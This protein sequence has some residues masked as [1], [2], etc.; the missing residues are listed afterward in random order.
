MLA[1]MSALNLAAVA[2]HP[3]LAEVTTTGPEHPGINP[4]MNGA[5]A[6]GVL[7]L[8]LFVTTRLNRDK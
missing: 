1:T 2:A 5:I 8:L 3:V 7:L 6:L 4:P